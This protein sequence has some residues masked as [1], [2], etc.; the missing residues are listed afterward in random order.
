MDLKSFGV[1]AQKAKM[2]KIGDAVYPGR[3]FRESMTR[4]FRDEWGEFE[5]AFDLKRDLSSEQHWVLTDASHLKEEILASTKSLFIDPF[6]EGNT[7]YRAQL[8]PAIAIM[9]GT[10][11]DVFL[12]VDGDYLVGAKILEAT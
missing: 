12:I 7:F 5:Y 4:I 10:K 6:S 8:R 3:E 11:A 9:V 2:E 1:L